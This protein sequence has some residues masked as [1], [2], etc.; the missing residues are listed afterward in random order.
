MEW[1]DTVHSTR[2]LLPELLS[3]SEVVD[4]GLSDE[5]L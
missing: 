1:N 3:E 5:L 4:S 2:M